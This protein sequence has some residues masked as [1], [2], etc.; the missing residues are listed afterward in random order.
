MSIYPIRPM[1]APGSPLPANYPPS[2]HCP[3]CRRGFPISHKLFVDYF[4][5]RLLTCPNDG[6]GRRFSWWRSMSSSVLLMSGSGTANAAIQTIG[7]TTL[8]TTDAVVG[9]VT[10]LDLATMGVPK[11]G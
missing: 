8:A 7:C 1:P 6:C 9:T 2:G 3:S 10:T 11:H 4:H 5:R